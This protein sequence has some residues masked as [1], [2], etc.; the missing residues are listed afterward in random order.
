MLVPLLTTIASEN[1]SNFVRY[2]TK[3]SYK[4]TIVDKTTQALRSSVRQINDSFEL[5]GD[6]AMDEF[7][8]EK[9]AN[10]SGEHVVHRDG[11]PAL[12]AK[13]EVHLIGVRSNTAAP[14]KE[15]ANWFSKSAPCPECIPAK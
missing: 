2:S 1:R 4:S 13:D 8:V 9:S 12:P 7:F 11:C 15:A 14:L 5:R 3:L 10:A 6:I